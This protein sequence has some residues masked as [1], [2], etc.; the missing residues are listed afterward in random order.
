[1]EKSFQSYRR[2]TEKKLREYEK[3]LAECEVRIKSLRRKIQ[4]AEGEDRAAIQK[5]LDDLQER[6]NQAKAEW[7]KVLEQVER[8]SSEGKTAIETA[9]A[10]AGEVRA[11][12]ARTARELLKATRIRVRAVQKGVKAGI[13]AAKE[14]RRR[15]REEV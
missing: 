14:A 11:R 1:M 7:G 15:R 2:Q 13:Q 3:R 12:S 6:Y 8:T 5:I 4:Q 9:L 10:A